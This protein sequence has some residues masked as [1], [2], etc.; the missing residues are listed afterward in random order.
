[1]GQV[2]KKKKKKMIK[3]LNIRDRVINFQVKKTKQE[4]KM[5]TLARYFNFTL[6]H[7][8]HIENST[9]MTQNGKEKEREKPA[10]N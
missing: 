3:M 8:K 6:I 1:M 7:N 4:K 10:N 9:S 5:S 2:I